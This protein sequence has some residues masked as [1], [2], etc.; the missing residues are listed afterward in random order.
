M[1][2]VRPLA[3]SAPAAFATANL[4]PHK[5]A[6]FGKQAKFF[7]LGGGKRNVFGTPTM[8]NGGPTMERDM[9]S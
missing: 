9:L 6:L 5:I 1:E 4:C 8:D 7:S 3:D 2:I